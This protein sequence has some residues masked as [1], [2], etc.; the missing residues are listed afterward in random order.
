MRYVG[1]FLAAGSV[2]VCCSLASAQQV[3]PGYDLFQSL[4]G[5]QFM[6]SPFDGVPLG[7]FAFPNPGNTPRRCWW[8]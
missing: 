2:L 1:L 3:D 5:T 8:G 7:T 4:P 6:G